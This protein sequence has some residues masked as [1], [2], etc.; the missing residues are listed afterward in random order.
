M[1]QVLFRAKQLEHWRLRR[2]CGL[3]VEGDDEEIF[4]VQDEAVLAVRVCFWW[5]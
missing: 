5:C 4:D 3:G 2:Y 1:R